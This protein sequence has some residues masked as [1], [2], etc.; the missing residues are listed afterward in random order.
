MTDDPGGLVTDIETRTARVHLNGDGLVVV[1]IR[2]GARQTISD[3]KANL[4]SALSATAGQRRPLL[5]DIRRAQPLDAEV[6]HHYSGSV[7]AAG[8]VAIAILVESSPLGRMM[9]NVY[10]RVASVAVPM[11]LFVDEKRAVEWLIAHRR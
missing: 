8:F 5:V 2:D 6:R 11:Q 3:A 7:L 9:G 10:L 1:R 4:A